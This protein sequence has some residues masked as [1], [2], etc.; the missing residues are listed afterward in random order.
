MTHEVG[1]EGRQQD[2]SELLDDE[3][4]RLR[5]AEGEEGRGWAKEKKVRHEGDKDQGFCGASLTRRARH[6]GCIR[7]E[8]LGGLRVLISDNNNKIRK[9][10]RTGLL[11]ERKKCSSKCFYY[12]S[13]TS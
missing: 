13:T 2:A 3:V 9:G 5:R 1:E 6:E 8:Q 10:E 11:V 12:L 7:I 4:A